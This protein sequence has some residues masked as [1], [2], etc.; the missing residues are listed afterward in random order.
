MLLSN[1]G[2]CVVNLIGLC[3]ITSPPTHVFCHTNELP[4]M[5]TALIYRYFIGPI[6]GLIA[7]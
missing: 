7:S 6:P 2:S 3:G 4:H 1:V 5:K